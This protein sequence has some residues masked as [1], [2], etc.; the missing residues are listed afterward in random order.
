MYS[1]TTPWEMQ[2]QMCISCSGIKLQLSL[3]ASAAALGCLFWRSLPASFVRQNQNTC[4][5]PPVYAFDLNLRCCEYMSLPPLH[6]CPNST[7]QSQR[8]WV[9]AL[10]CGEGGRACRSPPAPVLGRPGLSELKID[11]WGSCLHPTLL[12]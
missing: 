11:T 10:P 6:T 8:E 12:P 3:A 5:G 4:N 2:C 7:E 1:A 9:W